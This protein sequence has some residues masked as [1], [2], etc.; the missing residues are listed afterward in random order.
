MIRFDADAE[1]HGNAGFDTD[2][3]FDADAGFP[4]HKGFGADDLF[5]ARAHGFPDDRAFSSWHLTAGLGA[6]A[7]LATA[8][9]VW[10]TMATVSGWHLAN[11][12]AEHALASEPARAAAT[13]DPA[14][15]PMTVVAKSDRATPQIEPME[16][17]FSGWEADL[18]RGA[19]TFVPPEDFAVDQTKARGFGPGE[20][21]AVPNEAKAALAVD[22]VPAP[23]TDPP[24]LPAHRTF[25]PHRRLASSEREADQPRAT[26][27][28]RVTSPKLHKAFA[29][30]TYTEKVVEQ[31]DAGEV[32]YRYV[33][34]TCAPPHMVDVCYMPAET[35]RSI[36]VQRY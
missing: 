4:A 32:K 25:V 21:R 3:V 1:F 30:G 15:V 18:D 12:S 11:P 29:R 35:R 16:L 36:V 19:K 24:A 23:A 7:S 22:P 13:P 20:A 14:T 6:V 34:R 9:V 10:W 5:D 17:R 8:G 33:R 2:E 31:G 27:Q 28:P 26:S